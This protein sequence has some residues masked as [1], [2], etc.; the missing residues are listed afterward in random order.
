MNQLEHWIREQLPLDPA[1][2]VQA[3][4]EAQRRATE[5][6]LS[7]AAMVER[8]QRDRSEVDRLLTVVV[9][10]ETWLFRHEPAFEAVRAWLTAHAGRRVQMV[11]LGCARGAEPLSLAATAASV[12]RTALDTEI[13]GIDW[14]EA[15]LRDAALGAVS[16]LAQRG[17]LPEWAAHWFQP[18]Q[19]G[20]IRLRAEALS[21]IQW[22]RA[23][24]VLD[25]LPMAVDVAMC[26]N[27]AIYLSQQARETLR[28]RLAAMVQ[29]DGL[30]CLGHAD[31]T[32]LWEGAFEGADWS[33]GFVF[34]HRTGP[35]AP[36]LDL[37]KL[38]QPTGSTTRPWTTQPRS[39]APSLP[40]RLPAAMPATDAK[41]VVPQPVAQCSMASIQTLADSGR[42]DQASSMLETLLSRDGLQGDAWALLGA[43]RLGQGRHEDAE[44]CFRKVV[45]LQPH[46]ALSLL[47]LSALAERRGDRTAA[48]RL[49]L[50]AARAAA[51]EAS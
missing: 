35:V 13:I 6:R 25:A 9:P 50:R 29:P 24:L 16:P 40:T 46:H 8:L 10:P 27:V 48:D 38:P 26:R 33:G 28:D 17:P 12:G 18:D 22:R 11:S 32:V 7:E 44:E 51:G 34:R 19:R 36:P 5:L 15:H 21:M 14:N 30:L 41:A 23:D 47:Q 2:S 43:V 45:Y 1:V 37:A 49:R 31:P 20:W 39:A 42:L 4:R 3:V